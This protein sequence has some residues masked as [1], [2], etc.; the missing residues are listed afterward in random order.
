[1]HSAKEMYRAPDITMAFLI[2]LTTGCLTG[3]QELGRGLGN[4]QPTGPQPGPLVPH[5]LAPDF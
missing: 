5:H 4:P 2:L 1:M 3:A